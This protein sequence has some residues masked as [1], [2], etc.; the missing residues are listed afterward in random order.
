MATNEKLKDL[1]KN[2]FFAQ[3]LIFKKENEMLNIQNLPSADPQETRFSLSR[4]NIQTLKTGEP[5][6][7]EV[8]FRDIPLY[9][10]A[11]LAP[12]SSMRTPTKEQLGYTTSDSVE[13]VMQFYREKLLLSGWVIE[14]ELP[15]SEY[16]GAQDLAN[17]PECQKLS[18][19]TLTKIQGSS[20]RMAALNATR[21]GKSCYIGATEMSLP[22]SSAEK[23]VIS[24]SCSR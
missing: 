5:Q 23:T 8:E 4:G 11:E 10:N 12:L 6:I 15:L 2:N 1:V 22:D 18:P 14:N 13:K 17:C 9:P 24:I 19:E 7:S 20:M 16:S 3:A 21:Q